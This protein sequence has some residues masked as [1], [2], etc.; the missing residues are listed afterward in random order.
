MSPRLLTLKDYNNY[1]VSDK[2][3]TGCGIESEQKTG[4][5]YLFLQTFIPKLFFTPIPLMFINKIPDEVHIK[6]ELFGIGKINDTDLFIFKPWVLNVETS[7][8]YGHFENFHLLISQ[9]LF[10]HLL[11]RTVF[12]EQIT[13]SQ[14]KTTRVLEDITQLDLD[15]FGLNK[16][17]SIESFKTPKLIITRLFFV[18]DELICKFYGTH[19]LNISEEL[20]D[21]YFNPDL[22]TWFSICGQGLKEII[23]YIRL[24]INKRTFTGIS[25]ELII[26]KEFR[27][28]GIATEA[29]S[30][31]LEYIKRSSFT[32]SA[33]AKAL[34]PSSMRVLEKCGFIPIDQNVSLGHF[35]YYVDLIQAEHELLEKEFYGNEANVTIQKK[36]KEKFIRYF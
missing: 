33:N 22:N 28:L 8:I 30:G 2:L 6:F 16:I 26:H 9:K 29:V 21:E 11:A 7:Y 36:Y 35:N 24:Y 25:I 23:G 1:F 20:L 3:E 27:G 14:L 10:Y 4:E 32:F 18:N 15:H 19:Y 34:H 13:L 31:I 5:N 17:P 12:L